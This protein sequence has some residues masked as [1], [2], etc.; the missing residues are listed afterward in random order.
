MSAFLYS[1]GI[2]IS[3]QFLKHFTSCDHM[4]YYNLLQETSTASLDPIQ[5]RCGGLTELK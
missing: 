1:S 3:S 5:M 2:S 4:S